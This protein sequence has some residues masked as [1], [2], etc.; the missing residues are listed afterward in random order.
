MTADDVKLLDHCEEIRQLRDVVVELALYVEHRLSAA[1]RDGVAG[2]GAGAGGA[3]RGE[4]LV[5][6]ARTYRA[7][8]AA[9][10]ARRGRRE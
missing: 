6:D 10:R 5:S 2:D 4:R 9:V 3:D 7:G 8:P 1:V